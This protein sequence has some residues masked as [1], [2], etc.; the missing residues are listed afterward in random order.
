M[1]SDELPVSRIRWGGIA[2]H[3]RHAG[4][5]LE[6]RTFTPVLAGC[7]VAELD[8]IPGAQVGQVR[9]HGKAWRDLTAAERAELLAWLIRWT[10]AARSAAERI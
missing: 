6:L 5:L 1:V 4:A 10:D 8:F 7:N 9:E 3:A 2:G